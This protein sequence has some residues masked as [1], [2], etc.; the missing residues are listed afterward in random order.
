MEIPGQFHVEINNHLSS[1]QPGQPHDKPLSDELSLQGAKNS[2][3]EAVE[4]ALR[5]SRGH[6]DRILFLRIIAD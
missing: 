4:A 1:S 6:V 2:F 5:A 3:S